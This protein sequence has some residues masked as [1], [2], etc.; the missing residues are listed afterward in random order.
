MYNEIVYVFWVFLIF[1]LEI[2]IKNEDMGQ[3][4]KYLD[5]KWD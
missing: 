3:A 5:V 1:I 4:T 2:Y